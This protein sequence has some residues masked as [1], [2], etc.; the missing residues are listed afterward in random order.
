MTRIWE[1]KGITLIQEVK[2]LNEQV[3]KTLYVLFHSDAMIAHGDINIIN[4][5]LAEEDVIASYEDDPDSVTLLLGLVLD[6]KTLPT[7]MPAELKRDY[8]IFFIKKESGI[9]TSCE[10]QL[11]FD[12]LI[13]AIEFEI[14]DP[15][16]VEIDDMAVIIA[17]RQFFVL[18][19][20]EQEC[21]ITDSHKGELGVR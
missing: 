20:L 15:P 17:K 13:K 16:T 21:T 11:D 5:Y 18:Q 2:E 19:A 7:K 12:N 9:E 3:G 4:R 6:I 14:E 8:R 10:E 1:D